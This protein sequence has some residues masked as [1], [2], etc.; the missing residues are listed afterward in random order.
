M[1]KPFGERFDPF[2]QLI[3]RACERGLARIGRARAEIAQLI[4]EEKASKKKLVGTVKQFAMVN[5]HASLKINVVDAGGKTSVWSFEMTGVSGLKK[6]GWE[7]ASLKPGDKVTVT[8]FPLRF[9]SF[10]GQL[11][12]VRLPGGRELSALAE[13]DR[14]YP[15]R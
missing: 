4:R 2:R 13:A 7:P 8:F 10:G 11:L 15:K 14:G 5:P 3:E 6:L 1:L 9:G 12:D